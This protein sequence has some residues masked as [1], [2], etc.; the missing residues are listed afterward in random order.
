M[1]DMFNLFLEST[2]NQSSA[3][4]SLWIIRRNEK[5]P[6]SR[7]RHPHIHFRE[8]DRLMYPLKSP[9]PSPHHLSPIFNEAFRSNLTSVY[10]QKH[11]K[12]VKNESSD[13]MKN[14]EHRNV[15]NNLEDVITQ[16]KSN[17]SVLNMKE[18][19]TQPNSN[20]SISKKQLEDALNDFLKKEDK[21]QTDLL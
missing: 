8:I 13:E 11:E 19:L 7:Q 3:Q 1:N 18:S 12:R 17:E 14:N 20:A 9:H 4:K 6:I 16:L 5:K 21:K 15:T 2:N 10:H